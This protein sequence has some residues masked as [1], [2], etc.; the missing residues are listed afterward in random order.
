MEN[1]FVSD[2]HATGVVTPPNLPFHV[3][4]NDRN[5]TDDQQRNSRYNCSNNYTPI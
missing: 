3:A 5:D 4:D 1:V 2:S